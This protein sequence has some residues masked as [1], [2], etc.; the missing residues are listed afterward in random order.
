MRYLC[1]RRRSHRL[2]DYNHYQLQ[3]AECQYQHRLCGQQ[4][5]VGPDSNQ[6]T[7]DE[8]LADVRFGR[9]DERKHGDEYESKFE[10]KLESTALIP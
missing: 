9:S 1:S 4:Q 7:N 10:H 2:H 8:R 5:R 3:S 6:Y